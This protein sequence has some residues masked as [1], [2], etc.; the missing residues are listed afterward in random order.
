MKKLIIA[1]T[2]AAAVF[3]STAQAQTE[4]VYALELIEDSS[5]WSV[6]HYYRHQHMCMDMLVVVLN[7]GNGWKPEQVRC[8]EVE[9][10]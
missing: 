9:I 6:F 5:G 1:A 7:N 10:N 8:V 2:L 4:N 3:G